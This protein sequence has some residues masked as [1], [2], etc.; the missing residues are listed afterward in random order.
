MGAGKST[1][2]RQLAQQLGM[3]FLDLDDLIEEQVGMSIN[4]IFERKGE[5]WFREMERMLLQ[6]LI[7]LPA[8]EY[9]IATGGGTPC[10]Q[11]NMQWMKTHGSVYY[12]KVAVEELSKRLHQQRAARP[13]LRDLE[14]SDIQGFVE[15]KLE[16]REPIYSQA[17]R[18]ADDSEGQLE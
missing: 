5:A 8:G 7:F 16:E 6:S 10:Y 17:H 3:T 11:D 18:I 15:R 2:G 1:L 13:L 14:V 9:L 4:E 12:L